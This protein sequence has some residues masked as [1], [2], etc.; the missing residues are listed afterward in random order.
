[1]CFLISSRKTYKIA[2]LLFSDYRNFTFSLPKNFIG[3]VA[4]ESIARIVPQ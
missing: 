2:V 4:N 3:N 1:M